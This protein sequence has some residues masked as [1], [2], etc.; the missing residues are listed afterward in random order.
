[1]NTLC[2]RFT[3]FSK[4]SILRIG[5][6]TK[7]TPARIA[8]I[9]DM[10]L[11]IDVGVER[12]FNRKHWLIYSSE[13]D[14]FFVAIQDSFTGLVVTVLT[15]DYHRNLAWKVDKEFFVKAKFAITK[16]NVDVLL[17]DFKRKNTS[18]RKT[19]ECKAIFV[20]V[21]FLDANNT[22]K[23]KQLFTL[24]AEDV[25]HPIDHVVINSE[26]KESIKASCELKGVNYSGILEVLFSFKKSIDTKV[27]DWAS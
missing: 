9:V 12:V 4:H 20:K 10:G 18:P 8:D 14:D 26:L 15:I 16:D 2:H 21:R 23:T 17:V 6:R 27:V 19:E 22:V 5:Q 1:M 25:E 7:L 3:H 13:D 24:P 11:A